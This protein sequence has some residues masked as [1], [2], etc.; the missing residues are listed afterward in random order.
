MWLSLTPAPPQ[1]DFEASDKLGHLLAYAALM[2][3]FCR[4]YAARHARLAHGIAFVALG[5]VLELAQGA[6]GYRSYEIA[7]LLANALG[8]AAGWGAARL[9]EQRS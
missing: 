9:I 5:V 8:V 7:D 3:W 2:F 6:S 4:L 1:V